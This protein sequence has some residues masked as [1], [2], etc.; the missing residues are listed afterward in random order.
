MSRSPFPLALTRWWKFRWKN[1]PASRAPRLNKPGRF[2]LSYGHPGGNGG[3]LPIF[4]A[5]SK[6]AAP[7][8]IPIIQTIAAP[9]CGALCLLSIVAWLMAIN[10]PMNLTEQARAITIPRAMSGRRMR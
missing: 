1:N 8:A 5:L 9:P 10:A 3:G 6:M 2:A 7:Q 4:R